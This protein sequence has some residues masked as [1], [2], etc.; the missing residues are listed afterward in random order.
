MTRL[1]T[2]TGLIVSE[3]EL[4]SYPRPALKR[5]SYQSL[6]GSWSFVLFDEKNNIKAEG[7]II[8]PFAIESRLSKV[9]LPLLPNETLIYTLKFELNESVKKGGPLTLL[10][11]EAVDYKASVFL[12]GHHLGDHQGGYTPF[13]FEISKYLHDGDNTLIVK[14]SD[15][16]DT[17]LQERGKQ[18]LKP[19]GMWYTASSGI[20]GSVWLEGVASTYIKDYFIQSDLLNQTIRL[21]L[22]VSSPTFNYLLTVYRGNE[23]VL[24]RYIKKQSTTLPLEKPIE[25]SPDNPFLYTFTL[26]S[27]E[28]EV[29]GYFGFRSI[30]VGLGHKNKPV[31]YLNNKPYFINGLLDQGYWPESLLTPP[32]KAALKKD[33]LAAKN[34]GFNTLRKHLKFEPQMFYYLCD[35]LGMLVIQDMPNGGIYNFRVMSLNPTLRIRRYDDSKYKTFGR[36]QTS[37][38]LEFIE[39]MEVNIKRLKKHPSIIAWCPFNEGWGQFDAKEI[40]QIIRDLD[41][42]RLIDS[43]SGWFDQGVGDFNSVHEYFLPLKM[44]REDGRIAFISEF[45]GYSL[46]LEFHR[47]NE[48]KEYGYKKFSTLADFEAAFIKLYQNKVIPLFYEGLGGVIYTQLSDVE[49]ETNGLLTYDRQIAKLDYETINELFEKLKY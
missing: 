47:F 43:T 35:V 22:D 11:F 21:D 32:S 12:N 14:V 10:H 20:Y 30:R 7:E 2:K 17:G 15:P 13:T 36:A 46:P 44:P 37:N 3:S 34:Y 5:K 42:S 6:N 28:D 9:E 31:M 8:V 33:I 45:G 18:T 48:K 23:P 19:G 38:R 4:T 26:E 49:E 25:W 27:K 1:S 29:S 16:T 40:T 41:S 39:M 24:V